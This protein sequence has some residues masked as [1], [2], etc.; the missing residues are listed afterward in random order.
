VNC[1]ALSPRQKSRGSR[2]TLLAALDH[3]CYAAAKD[4]SAVYLGDPDSQC[5]TRPGGSIRRAAVPG[6]LNLRALPS[7]TCRPQP[8][9]PYLQRGD[10]FQ[11]FGSIGQAMLDLCAQFLGIFEGREQ[12]RLRHGKKRGRRVGSR[13]SVGR[14][15]WRLPI[16]VVRTILHVTCGQSFPAASGEIPAILPVNH[17][18]VALVEMRWVVDSALPGQLA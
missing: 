9:N 16:V 14:Q 1:P 11:T 6:R 17:A 7:P 10:Q 3:R 2:R 18:V 15:L 5:G 8:F 13:S 4:S 12:Y